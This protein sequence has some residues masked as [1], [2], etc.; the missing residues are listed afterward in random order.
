MQ[1][2]ALVLVSCL[3]LFGPVAACG[4]DTTEAEP[5]PRVPC[6][7]GPATLAPAPV[8]LALADS[9][10]DRVALLPRVR[11]G[12][13]WHGAGEDGPCALAADAVSC[14]AGSVGQVRVRLLGSVATVELEAALAAD[15]EALGLTGALELEGATGWLSNGFQSWSQSGV[16]ALGE[17]V[18]DAEVA[19]ALA[20]RGDDEVLREGHELSWQYTFVGAALPDGAPGATFFAGAT[21]AARWKPWARAYRGA[22]LVVE[23]TSGGAGEHVPVAAGQILAGEPFL[24]A[25]GD[26]LEMA[27]AGW[28]DAL[29]TR[30][31][32]SAPPAE[33]GWNSWYELWDGV[34]ET[35]VRANA[36]LARA[37]LEPRLA[38]GTP[39]R[40]VVDDGWEAAW[41]DWTPNAKFPSG[42]DGLAADLAADGFELGV[43]LAPLLAGAQSQ[44]YAAHPDWFLPDATYKHPK[45]GTMHVLDVTN[46]DAA[47]HLSSVIGTIVG[48]G[49]GL[50]KIDFLFAGAFEGTR[51]EPV[52]GMQA[53]ARALEL[54]RAAAGESTI[55]LAVGA[56]G[57]ASF[58]HV[59]A[60][61]VGADIA[62]E[63]TGAAWPFLPSQARSIAAHWALCR[64]TLCDAD[65]VL[66]RTLP[67]EEVETGG[68]IV[69][70]GGGALFLSDDLRVLPAERTTWGLDDERIGRALG[71]AP[72]TPLDPF[73]AVPP[74]TLTNVVVDIVT[75]KTTQLVPTRW[76]APSGAG[77]ALNVSDAPIVVGGVDVPA[78]A[79]R[80]LP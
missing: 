5:P 19:Q 27:F 53:Y 1:H 49:Y 11:V 38:P 48:W 6:E 75:Q 7:P 40:I 79:V 77:F 17:P 18:S 63:N 28:A 76:R 4:D 43:W 62:F 14:P 55:L 26:G 45:H 34:D 32:T 61:R 74:P 44:V 60:W 73:P 39:L 42:L 67:R 24:L 2:R 71:G 54:V 65:P 41:G 64:A 31:A 50:L 23:L 29:A 3:A 46:V 20:A 36:A 12:G 25:L 30:R 66:L 13:V 15:V 78:H 72:S 47:A 22:G 10:G 21:S 68:H 16:V 58:P 33:A 70:L 56:P 9:C 59:D 69:A 52:T 57:V 51:A 8:A 80:P 37:L 35:G